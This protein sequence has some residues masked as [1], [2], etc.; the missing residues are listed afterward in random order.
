[1]NA[2]VCLLLA[3]L[4]GA[5]GV[6][7]G[8]YHA[9]GLEKWLSDQ[10]ASPKDVEKRMHNCEVAVRYQMYH[11]L[12]LA[13]LGLTSLQSPM[14][15]LA[16]TS[17]AVFVLGMTCFSGGLYWMV[18]TGTVGHWA[19]VPFGGLMLILAWLMFGVTALGLRPGERHAPQDAGNN[20]SSK[21]LS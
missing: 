2:R 13:L 6:G 5:S 1:M 9:H 16:A 18:F 12:A 11:A 17:A 14:R 7:L 21:R 10:A 20:P 19:I 15:R 3:A 8:A 4:I